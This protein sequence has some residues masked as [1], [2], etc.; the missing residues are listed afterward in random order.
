MDMIAERELALHASGDTK[1]IVVRLGRPEL[2]AKGQNWRVL[3]E[4]QGPDAG[5]V[6]RGMV[7][8]EDSMQ[9][10]VLAL[11]ILPAELAAFSRRGELT[12]L[13]ERDLGFLPVSRA[14]GP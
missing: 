13:G 1:T 7:R 8:G 10:V 2:E 5:D 6:R 9:A 4:I 3:Y 12:W 11:Q 14:E